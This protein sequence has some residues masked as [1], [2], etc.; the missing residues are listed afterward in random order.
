MK[1]AA[2]KRAAPKSERRGAEKKKPP[3]QKRAGGPVRRPR[4]IAARVPAARRPAVRSHARVTAPAAR[5]VAPPRLK[6]PPRHRN[7]FTVNHLNE[8]DF[9]RDGLRSYAFVTA[10]PLASPPPPGGPVSG[11]RDPLAVTP[12]TDEVPQAASA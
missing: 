6:G 12:C 8:A 10:I 1:R 11:A 2:P 5:K 7:A 3:S 9:Q 4:K